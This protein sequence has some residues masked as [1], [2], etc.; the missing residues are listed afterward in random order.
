[1]QH[2]TTPPSRHL[3]AYRLGALALFGALLLPTTLSAGEPDAREPAE[4]YRQVCAH[5][6]APDKA[7]GPEITMAFPEA[8]HE[9]WRA[10]IETT[11]RHGRAAMPSFRPAKI[12]DAELKALSAALA[13]GELAEDDGGEE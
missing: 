13:R 8:A 1:M 2:T 9:S 6:H 7:V 4:V 3:S 5:C 12:S 10:Y 11:V